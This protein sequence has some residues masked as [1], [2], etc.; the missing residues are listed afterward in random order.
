MSIKRIFTCDA[1]DCENKVQTQAEHPPTFV[2][3]FDEPG[4]PHEPRHEF[5]FCTWDCLMKYAAKFEPP[6][7]IE[8]G[9]GEKHGN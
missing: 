9:E 3:V 6:I 2:T 1:E 8:P 5:H 4:Y 7:V